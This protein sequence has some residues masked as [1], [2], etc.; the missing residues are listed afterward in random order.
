MGTIPGFDIP[1]RDLTDEE[2]LRA[3]TLR[4]FR[5]FHYAA[6]EDFVDSV[7]GFLNEKVFAG[8]LMHKYPHYAEKIINA[9]NVDDI[10]ELKETIEQFDYNEDEDIDM[11]YEE[12]AGFANMTKKTRERINQVLIQI[13]EYYR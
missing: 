12:I 4:R 13:E 8:W 7:G 11:I 1:K 9:S 2:A 3:I 5:D 6:G 10:F